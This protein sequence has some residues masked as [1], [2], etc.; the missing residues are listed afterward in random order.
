[1]SHTRYAQASCQSLFV[2]VPKKNQASCL[3]AF[4]TWLFSQ[5]AGSRKYAGRVFIEPL[6]RIHTPL[7]FTLWTYVPLQIWKE[8][9]WHSRHM[10]SCV[11]IMSHSL[12]PQ[13][14]LA[15][16]YSSVG[17]RIEAELDII[18]GFF[19]LGTNPHQTLDLHFNSTQVFRK[20]LLDGRVRVRFVR[21]GI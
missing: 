6:S 18:N 21:V 16:I 14:Y 13:T 10:L 20:C 4:L 11:K 9:L 7:A 15:N 12:C 19:G 3:L 5:P 1:M 2:Y 17:N 8:Q